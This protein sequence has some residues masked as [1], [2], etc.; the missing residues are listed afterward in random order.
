MEPGKCDW[1]T[2]QKRKKKKKRKRC[3]SKGQ[4]LLQKQTTH[5]DDTLLGATPLTKL[6][7][8]TFDREPE[9]NLHVGFLRDRTYF[10]RTRI[11]KQNSFSVYRS[12]Q[13]LVKSLLEKYLKKR[14]MKAIKHGFSISP[15]LCLSGESEQLVCYMLSLSF[16]LSNYVL[17]FQYSLI[18]YF[19][20]PCMGS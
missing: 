4:V 19:S 3:L 6:D 13:A 20:V 7:T 1:D 11:L 12:K 5:W 8:N 16:V 2:I 15:G 9:S 14:R 10:Q 18:F 17:Y